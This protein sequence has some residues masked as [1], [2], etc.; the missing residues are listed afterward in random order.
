MPMF[1][2]CR[3][4]WPGSTTCQ[5]RTGELARLERGSATVPAAPRLRSTSTRQPTPPSGKDTCSPCASC[6]IPVIHYPLHVITCVIIFFLFLFFYYP[7]LV[8]P[9]S[10]VL[11]QVSVVPPL[12]TSVQTKRTPPM[13]QLK[14]TQKRPPSARFT[15]RVPSTVLPTPPR[16]FTALRN[17]PFTQSKR[18]RQ[19]TARSTLPRIIAAQRVPSTPQG[20]LPTAQ[21]IP[22]ELTM[23]TMTVQCTEKG[24]RQNPPPTAHFTRRGFK[25]VSVPRNQK[26]RRRRPTQG[27]VSP[28]KVGETMAA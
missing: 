11:P 19:R 21:C 25:S 5:T 7:S 15:P 28:G 9:P 27:T 1:A 13:A 24:P 23:A 14:M 16:G 3:I 17:A 4:L 22:R 8:R 6:S 26:P 18:T 2:C 20:R 10:A 12:W